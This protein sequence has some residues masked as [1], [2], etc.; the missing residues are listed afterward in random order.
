MPINILIDSGASVSVIRQDSL[1]GRTTIT[2]Q[3][4]DT[5][6]A[7]GLQMSLVGQTELMVSLQGGFSVP[8]NF[9]VAKEL[10]VECL[11]GSDFLQ[12]HAAVINY[13]EQTMTLGSNMKYIVPLGTGTSTVQIMSIRNS[14][15]L[16][17]PPRSIQ[18]LSAE[19]DGCPDSEMGLVEPVHNRAHI[20]TAR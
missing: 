5:I 10:S 3:S 19:L 13:A 11:L 17:I 20:I 16:T 7:N 6:V 12:R 18:I 2:P 4:C 8:H 1:P 15:T 14:R 9:H